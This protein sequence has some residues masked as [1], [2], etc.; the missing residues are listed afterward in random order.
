MLNRIKFHSVVRELREKLPPKYP[1]S[2]RL[3][4]FPKK[5]S[6]W[7]GAI[8]KEN[9]RFHIHLNEKLHWDGAINVLL[10]E[11]AHAL[12][13]SDNNHGEKWGRAFAR[14][15]RTIIDNDEN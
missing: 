9:K 11:W 5:E 8:Y 4:K 3:K 13:W 6:H 7:N 12:A 10:H 14:C 15:W 1:V 2:V